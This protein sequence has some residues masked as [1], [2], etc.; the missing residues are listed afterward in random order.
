MTGGA[1]LP[2]AGRRLPL[3]ALP[4]AGGAGLVVY[5]LAG[6]SLPLAAAAVALLGAAVWWVALTQAGAVDQ[7]AITARVRA[8][9]IAGLVAVAAYDLTRFGL[10]TVLTLSFEPFH[11]LPTF[12]RLF[13]GDGA[14]EAVAVA[15]GI[16]Y[17][18]ANG[19]GFAIGYALAIKRPGPAT[20]IAWGI[21]LE[22]CMAILYP[23]WLKIATLE[24]FLTV[25][26]LGHVAY[27][28]ALGLAMRAQV[29]R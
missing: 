29:R 25:S 7:R 15:A 4:F 20:G 21:G 8:G 17:H 14:P 13:V 28:G 24:E 26:A 5:I 22:L 12:G 23:T 11:V 18:V 3:L 9:A 19:V 6:V 27:G 1:D 16:A 2:T 10:V